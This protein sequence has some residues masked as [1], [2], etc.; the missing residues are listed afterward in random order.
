MRW[1][2]VDNH[3]YLGN[4]SRESHPSGYSPQQQP[5]DLGRLPHDDLPDGCQIIDKRVCHCVETDREP[6][7]EAAPHRGK[8]CSPP[9]CRARSGGAFLLEQETEASLS[10]S[11]PRHCERSATSELYCFPPCSG[12]RRS[13]HL[14]HSNASR[15]S[16][17][18]IRDR[19]T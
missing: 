9:C 17:R 2:D 5:Y 7:Q 16:E 12:P 6:R 3:Q 19:R 15:I 14:S 1:R 4:A 8:R 10:D 13:V 11:E 18:G